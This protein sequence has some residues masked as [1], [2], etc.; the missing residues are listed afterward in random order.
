MSKLHLLWAACAATTLTLAACGGGDDETPTPSP[1][2]APAPGP[3]PAPAPVP[4]SGFIEQLDTRGM[5][6]A[7]SKAAVAAA[8]RMPAS[9][10]V[11]SVVL[12]PL[13]V[14]KVAPLAEKGVALKIGEARDVATTATT[15]DMAR[16]LHWSTLADGSQ[17]AAVSFTAEGAKAIRLGVLAK[18]VPA[19]TV[20]RFYGAPGTEVVEV[21]AAEL[22]SLRQLNE[23]GGVLGDAARM[24]WSADTAGAT[25]T[26]EVQ[27]P[28]GATPTQLQLAVPT[29]SHWTRTLPEAIEAPVKAEAQ[30]GDSGSCNLDV[31]CQPS[32]DPQSRAVAHMIYQ[33][34]GGSYMCTGTLL[35]DTRNSQTPYF[36]SANHC[37][38][39]QEAAST[40][41]TYWFFRA[42]SC[43]SSPKFDQA[44]TVVRGGAVLRFTHAP[45]DATLLQLNSAVPASV[46]YAGSYYGN[47]V[48]TG[49]PVVGV[50]NPAGDL[51][52]Y[53]IGTVQGYVNCSATP[54]GAVSCTGATAANGNLFSI[55]WQKGVTEGGSS[56]SA[57]F[58]ESTNGR[59]YVVGNLWAGNA[60]CQNPQGTD[61][62][63]RFERSFAAGINTWLAP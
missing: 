58:A 41:T 22:N 4:G 56:G 37:I 59:R 25:S 17:V 10:S 54:G 52:K 32:L 42:A 49:T 46:V 36:L 47:E 33:K 23:S 7:A 50:H 13:P 53:S 35:N 55:G 16:A 63:G 8:S 1:P 15:D 20:L 43:N 48:V 45:T 30:I 21:S 29:L 60:S 19:G 57:I 3:A 31:M 27:L 40:L 11:A 5:P 34:A 61:S 24:Y 62:Y 2:P 44:A 39:T 6:R 51:Q 14:V 38:S 18:S 28:P 26:L 9:A 12:G